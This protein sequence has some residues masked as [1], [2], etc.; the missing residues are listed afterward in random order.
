MGLL[1]AIFG[2]YFG[3]CVDSMY[4]KGTSSNI[5]ETKWYKSV[6]RL[7]LIS[8][9]GAPLFYYYYAIK[10]ADLNIMTLYLLRTSLPFFIAAFLLFAYSKI[11]LRKLRLINDN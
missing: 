2:A 4:F 11:L 1:S 9:F 7:L 8:L 3:L 10:N 5:N 6:L